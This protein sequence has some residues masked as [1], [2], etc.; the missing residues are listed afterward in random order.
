MRRSPTGDSPA[1][2]RARR[3]S[4]PRRAGL[5]AQV[6]LVRSTGLGYAWRRL[7][8][9]ADL[10]LDAAESLYRSIWANAAA[11]VG[12]EVRELGGGVFEP[13]RGERSTRARL[14]HVTLDSEVALRLALDTPRTPGLHYHYQVADPG[15]RCVSPC[16][17][18]GSYSTPR[19]SS[20]S[21]AIGWS[22]VA[23]G[24][25]ARNCSIASRIS[26]ERERPSR[27]IR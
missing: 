24:A 13:P 20:C 25:A 16:R 19:F 6:D 8:D 22:I 10:R 12:A 9:R 3:R 21:T 4:R 15:T 23:S 7:R 14:H 5:A 27:A 1:P 11:E 26:G 17:C 18:C 2:R